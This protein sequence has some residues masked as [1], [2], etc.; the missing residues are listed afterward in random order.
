MIII[1]TTISTIMIMIVY[2]PITVTSSLRR[3]RWKDLTGRSLRDAGGTESAAF[4]FDAAMPGARVV[5]DALK[6]RLPEIAA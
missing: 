4:F 6:V 2:S 1:H 3:A 5:A